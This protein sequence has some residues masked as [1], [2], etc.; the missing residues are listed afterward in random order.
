M[1]RCAIALGG[2]CTIS[3]QTYATEFILQCPVKVHASKAFLKNFELPASTI[4]IGI[5]DSNM[6]R[7]ALKRMFSCFKNCTV[8]LLGEAYSEAKNC[9]DTI[10]GML[11]NFDYCI[12]VLDQN[13]DY[14]EGAVLGEV[15]GVAPLLAL[16]G[17]RVVRVSGG[18]R[19]RRDARG[20]E[21]DEAREAHVVDDAQDAAGTTRPARRFR[22][23]GKATAKVR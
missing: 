2:S 5:D 14:A 6:Q 23:T 15:C 16:E 3:F 19:L 8:L 10:L 9:T 1:Q 4:V 17:V 7:V 18:A 22:G 20:A 12:C 13:L 11:K 21:E